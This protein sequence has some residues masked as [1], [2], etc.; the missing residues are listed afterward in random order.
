MDG[1]PG[2]LKKHSQQQA[3]SLKSIKSSNPGILSN[4]EPLSVTRKSGALSKPKPISVTNNSSNSEPLAVN[5]ISKTLYRRDNPRQQLEKPPHEENTALQNAEKEF[6]ES[7]K[8]FTSNSIIRKIKCEVVRA[9]NEE[10][11]TAEITGKEVLSYG[12]TLLARGIRV[13][14][15][16]MDY[17]REVLPEKMEEM[18]NKAQKNEVQKDNKSK[19]K[20]GSNRQQ[21]TGGLGGEEG[22]EGDVKSSIGTGTGKATQVNPVFKVSLFAGFPSFCAFIFLI[23]FLLWVIIM[24]L[25]NRFLGD[26]YALP[27][28]KFDK[29]TTQIVYSI[30]FAITSL[31]LMFYL[32]IDYYRKIEDELDIVQIFKQVI[33]ASYILWPIAI[34]IIGSGISKAFYKISCNGN[35]PNVLSW[36]K[37]VESTALYVL[38]ICVLITVIFLFKPIN[39]MYKYTLPRMIRRFFD[40]GNIWVAV[41]LKLMVIYIVL[42]MITIML[43]DIIS[44]KIVFFISKLNK[45]VE[46]PPVDCNAEE[47]EKNAKQS[48][49][50]NILEE[51]YMYISGIIV[52]IIIIFI[53]LIQSPHP[54]FASV[55][56]IND[57]IGSA[58]QRVSSLST[59]YIVKRGTTKD[60]S[61]QKKGSGFFSSFPSLPSLP[62]IG[63]TSNSTDA[64]PHNSKDFSNLTEISKTSEPG[65]TETLT[66][67]ESATRQQAQQS[68][69]TKEARGKLLPPRVISSDLKKPEF[70]VLSQI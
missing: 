33:G 49:V 62:N 10:E 2:K 47:E 11:Q 19:K 23:F 24:G 42:R 8:P 46:A 55:Y 70:N 39:Y 53:M 51:I 63:S 29:K 65:V 60:C 43:E 59:Q 66:P 61:E 27:N 17:L 30:F 57:N 37:I 68:T 31:V 64:A 41:T 58:L 38:G 9:E 3:P 20:K 56:K 48:E 7:L 22:E 52:C 54:Y 18:I 67:P 35:K 28:V 44:N 26:E 4:S 12:V 36:A 16:T 1:I 25:L 34:L 14:E 32:F 5:G 50:A 13:G 21:M 45:D 40:T 69:T 6:H 15:A